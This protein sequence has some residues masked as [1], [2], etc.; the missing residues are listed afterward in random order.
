MIDGY[1]RAY[2]DSNQEC[3]QNLIK[4]T[5]DYIRWIPETKAECDSLEC[6]DCRRS[7]VRC[8]TSDRCHGHCDFQDSLP[9]T[10]LKQSALDHFVGVRQ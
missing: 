6:V 8:C 9:I 4:G 3:D 5:S 7:L 10:I 1:I 2:G